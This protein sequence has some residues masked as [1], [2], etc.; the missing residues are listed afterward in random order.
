MVTANTMYQT[1]FH[2][3]TH[4]TLSTILLGNCYLLVPVMHRYYPYLCFTGEETKRQ[5]N[6]VNYP[7]SRSL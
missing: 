4:L 5:R 7:Q 2:L 6:R 1:F 3:L